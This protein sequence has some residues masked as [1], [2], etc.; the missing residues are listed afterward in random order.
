[1]KL[2][3]RRPRSGTAIHM[4]WL[5]TG[6]T[7]AA[8]L[9]AAGN[10]MAH[11]GRLPE[12]ALTLVRQAS[13]LLAQNPSMTGE[14]RERLEAALK[15]RKPEGVRLDQVA[16][17][18]HALENSDIA[19]ARR[20]LML[21]MMPAGRPMPPAGPTHVPPSSPGR[22]PSPST[23][24]RSPG[25]EPSGP[26]SVDAAMKMAEPLR[27]RFAGST[28]EIMILAVAVGLIGFGLLSLWRGGEIVRP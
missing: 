17:A 15:S 19:A 10:V 11:K 9:L 4:K 20:I 6:V 25:V 8:L 23:P 2:V 21:S 1:M 13:A 28:A 5:A 26:P 16:E 18:L 12:D 27:V 14:V 22:P 7:A 3:P 24:D